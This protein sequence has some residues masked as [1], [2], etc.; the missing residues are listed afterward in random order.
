MLASGFPE[1]NVEVPARSKSLPRG[2][3][4]DINNQRTFLTNLSVKL[5]I[6]LFLS[7]VTKAEIKDPSDW[8][9]LSHHQFIQH[10]A[11]GLLNHYKGSFIHALQNIFPGSF[12]AAGRN[13]YPHQISK[14]K[15]KFSKEQYMLFQCIKQ[16]SFLVTCSK[17]CYSYRYVVKST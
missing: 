13:A 12:W 10:G 7:Q 17:W 8:Y 3:W 6:L 14:G 11:G 16:A 5:S 2:Y 1:L 15:S 9:K 4:K